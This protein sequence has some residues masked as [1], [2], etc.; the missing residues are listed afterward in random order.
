MVILRE[1][2]KQGERNILPLFAACPFPPR[3]TSRPS[4]CSKVYGSNEL[5]NS[6]ICL[7]EASPAGTSS[8]RVHAG[9]TGPCS[10]SP[11]ARQQG[12]RQI[13]GP[14][15]RR[16]Q[17]EHALLP[18]E[19]GAAGTRLRAPGWEPGIAGHRARLV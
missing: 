4:L 6:S 2:Q 5:E 16:A 10:I 14:A 15:Q 3:E 13:R 18:T 12:G 19:L 11:S 8:Q 1:K 7:S 17:L 9:I